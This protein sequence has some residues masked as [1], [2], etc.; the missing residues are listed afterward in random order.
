[1]ES[2]ILQ[3]NPEHKKKKVNKFTTICDEDKRGRNCA[4]IWICIKWVNLPWKF[5]I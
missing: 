1:M 2:I 3:K 4:K 5:M